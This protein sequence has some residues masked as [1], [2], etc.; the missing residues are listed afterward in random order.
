MSRKLHS[1]CVIDIESSC[2]NKNDPDEGINEIIEVGS[3]IIDIKK[4]KILPWKSVLV[5]PIRSKVS[6]FCA[7]LTG[8]TQE[9]VDREG[10][11]FSFICKSL[12]EYT[13]KI[14]WASWGDYDR[15]MFED[16]CKRENIPYPFGRTHIN[17]KNI[18]ALAMGCTKEV[19]I[20]EALEICEMKFAGR[21]HRGGPD[22]FN[23]ARAL[24][25]G[26][27]GWEDEHNE[28]ECEN[29]H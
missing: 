10:L 25:T 15:I 21:N 20:P 13:E 29:I 28:Q 22:S 4:R 11:E 1:V 3:T 16:Q 17:I 14:T 27:L 19:S 23:A 26:V 5:K 8:I 12:D 7:K 6:P 2:W 18:F 9:V 24:A